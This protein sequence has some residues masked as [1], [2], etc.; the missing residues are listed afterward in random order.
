MRSRWVQIRFLLVA[1]LVASGLGVAASSAAGSAFTATG[2]ARQVY[3]TGLTPG[4]KVSLLNQSGDQV[5]SKP[6]DA[7]GGLIFYDVT[8]GAGYRAKVGST[9]S[10]PVTVHS[11]AA[12]PWSTATYDQQI[13]DHG[14]GYL[15]TRDGTQLAYTVH[16]PTQPAG[17]GTPEVLL[18]AGPAY[19]KPY[20]TLIEYSGYGYARE[21]GPVSGLA[22]IANVMGFA[23]VDISMRGTGCS[24]GAFNF[25]EPLQNLDGYDIIETI[26]KQSWVKGHKVGMMGISYGGISQLFTAALQPPS[27]AA[28]SPLSVLDATATTL[29]PGGVL[30]TGFAVAWALERQEQAKPAG[31]KAGQDWAYARI[32]NGDTACKANQALHGQAQ[33][34]MKTIRENDHYKPAVA[35]PLDPVTFVHKINVPVFMACQFQDE[36]T[37]GHCPSL[38]AHFTGT[39]K[40]WFTFTNGAHIDSIDPET[41]NRWYD[42][43][44]IYVADTAPLQN[45]VINAAAAPVVYEA[46]MGIPQN[47]P[48]TLPLDPIQAQPTLDLART[49]FEK[50]PSVRVL[51]D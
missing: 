14:Y 33:D 34:L 26:A 9:L 41:Y 2:S 45:A 35:D 21:S 8:P 42:F 18:P 15:T 17:L 50:L 7:Q 32:Q 29:Y 12:T 40:K 11:E 31:P 48:I 36:Q 30:N 24:S 49:A 25:F 39:K 23:V 47:N 46:A 6:A 16:P 4:A 38:V 10:P 27:L 13:P 44:Q 28:I 51:F 20:P 22:A 5:A 37:G 3:L 43:L 1:A 19:A